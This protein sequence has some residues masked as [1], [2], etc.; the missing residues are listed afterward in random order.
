RIIFSSGISTAEV[1]VPASRHEDD[2]HLTVVLRRVAVRR[3]RCKRVC[4]SDS[5]AQIVL[6]LAQPG[7]LVTRCECLQVLRRRRTVV[8]PFAQ[9]CTAVDHVNSKLA[10]L[11]LIGE[12]TPERIIRIKATDRLEGE[13][14]QAPG[15][16]RVMVV[17]GAL[18]MNL[19][20]AAKP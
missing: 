17:A 13:R 1:F 12:V 9:E 8:D 18:G 20:A 6:A 14:L 16:E 7:L 15:L 3:L 19:Y 4:A 11:V 10:L 5:I 2:R